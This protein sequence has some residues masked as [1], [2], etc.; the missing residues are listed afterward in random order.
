MLFVCQPSLSLPRGS[1]IT[2]YILNAGF[3]GVGAGLSVDGGQAVTTTLP[4][5]SAPSYQT[6]NVSLF[7]VQAIPYADH[8]ATL[9]VMDWNGGASS[10]YFDYALVN[11]SNPQILPNQ[12]SSIPP[13]PAS[14]G[15]TSSTSS[16]PTVPSSSNFVSTSTA[17]LSTAPVG[18]TY[19]PTPSPTPSL[20]PHTGTR[21]VFA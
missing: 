20:V 19:A 14:S 13:P 2:M 8:N 4:P 21:S 3:Q 18:I 7:S 11:Q 10:L 12:T 6:P 15:S 16:S 17:L 1:G 9:S 5:P